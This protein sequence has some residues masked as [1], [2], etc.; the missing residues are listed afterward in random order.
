MSKLNFDTDLCYY[1]RQLGFDIIYKELNNIPTDI[2]NLMLDYTSIYKSEDELHSD[3][4][5]STFYTFYDTAI[6]NI[7]NSNKRIHIVN[8]LDI[9]GTYIDL[10]TKMILTKQIECKEQQIDIDMRYYCDNTGRIDYVR[11]MYNS[12][13]KIY[14]PW[15]I[16]D[17]SVNKIDWCTNIR[18]NKKY[19]IV[20]I[21]CAHIT[22]D[23]QILQICNNITYNKIILITSLWDEIPLFMKSL[24][25]FIQITKFS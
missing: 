5:K 18:K 14:F 8:H 3:F 16:R 7:L 23:E 6:H 22:T 24:Q 20:L 15:M 12:Y 19:D 9:N 17:L 4:F 1:T 13:G 10:T 2:I 25:Q 21:D 11:R